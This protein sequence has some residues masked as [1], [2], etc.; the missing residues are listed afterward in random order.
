LSS[1]IKKLEVIRERWI[2]THKSAV[3]MDVELEITLSNESEDRLWNVILFVQLFMPG[4]KILDSSNS[5]LV[6]YTNQQ[7]RKLL[8]EQSL[9]DPEAKRLLEKVDKHEIYVIWIRLLDN[10][11]INPKEPRLVK[12]CFRDPTHPKTDPHKLSL[13]SIPEY[14]DICTKPKGGTYDVFYIVTVPENSIIDYEITEKT[15]TGSETEGYGIG[16]KKVPKRVELTED[17]RMYEDLYMHS[18]SIRFP[19][20][21]EEI[22]FG[23]R[24]KV[25]PQNN[26]RQFFQ[27][28]VYSLIGSSV[29]FTLLSLG[30]ISA[31][32]SHILKPIYENLNVLFGGLVTVSVAAIGFSNKP[33]LNKTRFWFII[34]IVISVIGFL[35]K[36]N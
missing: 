23:I 35:F 4:L 34:P 7:T 31:E 25:L 9:E 24:Y 5:E 17:D 19:P 3:E 11:P 29:F 21:D 16:R 22:R 28:V 10:A 14:E 2:V 1:G 26:E 32:W 36:S 8:N 13:F 20:L 6:Y 33:L 12:L 18:L 27:T 15:K 30:L